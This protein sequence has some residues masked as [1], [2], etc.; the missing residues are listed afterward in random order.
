MNDIAFLPANALAL[1]IRQ[2]EIT[3]SEVLEAHLQRIS[4][5]NPALNAVVTIDVEQARARARKLDEALD[6]GEVIGLLH[7]VPVTIKDAFATEGLRTTFGHRFMSRHVP[8]R[9]ATV[10]KRL[11]D[12]GAVVL[13]KTNIPELSWDWQTNSPIFGRTNNPFDHGCTPGGSGGGGAAAVAAGLS[14]IDIG[15]DGAGSIRVPAHFCGVFGFMPTAHRV[16][17]AGHMEIHR[18][19][20]STRSNLASFGALARSIADLRL[21]LTIIAGPDN[22]HADLPPVPLDSTEDDR[23]LS[24]CRFAWTDDFAGVPVTS[25]TREALKGL[26]EK[27]QARGCRVERVAP[28]DFDINEALATCGELW[29]YEVGVQTIYPARLAL[30][31]GYL[32]MFGRSVWSLGLIRGLKMNA[33]EHHAALNRRDL[34]ILK[35][36]AFLSDWDAWICPV[37]STPAFKH[38]RTGS[39]ISV[40]DKKIS[41]S[42][43]NGTYAALFNLTENPVVVIPVT[44]TQN[45]LPIGV[46]I[47]GRRW[48][49]LQLLNTAELMTEVTNGCSRPPT[50]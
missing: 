43:A 15:A 19:M 4:K 7:G 13:G 9:N 1:A 28:P 16:S 37:A 32:P 41:Y 34:L 25:E 38:C 44:R 24:K 40:D 18:N 46:Q 47:I 50:Y 10:V 2:G 30:R 5:F 3:S 23:E 42:Q 39:R 48:K 11:L 33:R 8:Q 20:Q 36:E 49:D 45:G 22:I 21:A 6:R 35:M 17:G 26:V 27:L 12:A 31:V 14:P 29:G